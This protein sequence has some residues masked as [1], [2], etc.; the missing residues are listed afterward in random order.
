MFEPDKD[1][2]NKK[3]NEMYKLQSN[4]LESCQN[5]KNFTKKIKQQ[6]LKT[7]VQQNNERKTSM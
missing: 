5:L 4:L 2:I 6:K 3:N 1:E 7:I